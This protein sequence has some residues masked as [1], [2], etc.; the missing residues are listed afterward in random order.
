M[1]QSSAFV[2]MVFFWLNDEAS[3]EL[4]QKMQE[5][6]LT[7]LGAIPGV[8]SIWAGKPAGTPRDVVDNSYDLGLIVVLD[9]SAGHDAY[10]IDP[11]HVAFV[12]KYKP[13][14]KKL[15]VFDTIQ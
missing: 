7:D 4:K 8:R 15:Q 12:G 10:Q 9:D 6:C 13:Y 14:F 11:R 5:D 3:D 1:S 2:H